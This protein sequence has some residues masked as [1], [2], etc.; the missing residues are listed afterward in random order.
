MNFL[1]RWTKLIIPALAL[2]LGACSEQLSLNGAINWIEVD[3]IE[4]NAC[5]S[6]TAVWM[7]TEAKQ[8]GHDEWMLDWSKHNCEDVNLETCFYTY[9]NNDLKEDWLARTRPIVK[10]YFGQRDVEVLATILMKL[11]Y[12]PHNL[13]FRP[14]LCAHGSSS[15]YMFLVCEKDRSTLETFGFKLGSTFDIEGDLPTSPTSS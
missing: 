12:D 4:H 2:T 15:I 1:V 11:T 7:G 9:N 8:C 6:K 3:A 10:E 13:E 5:A 14:A